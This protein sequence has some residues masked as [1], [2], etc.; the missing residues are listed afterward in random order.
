MV[1][2]PSIS[3]ATIDSHPSGN[4]S[5]RFTG[6]VPSNEPGTVQFLTLSQGTNS[7]TLAQ[8]K[9]LIV[10]DNPFDI[11][12]NPNFE[13]VPGTVS[14]AYKVLDSDGKPRGSGSMSGS[15]PGYTTVT[16]VSQQAAS[17]NSSTR[18]LTLTFSTQNAKSALVVQ[19]VKDASGSLWTDLSQTTW[20]DIDST[21]VTFTGKRP[22]PGAVAVV[23]G[24]IDGQSFTKSE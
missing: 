24:K 15:V 13:V 12:V 22:S 5:F 7:W 6:T 19:S 4:P 3:A 18:T 8:A 10:G 14:I 9:S 17:G 11:S 20:E 23:T 1:A 16:K 2:T 21:S